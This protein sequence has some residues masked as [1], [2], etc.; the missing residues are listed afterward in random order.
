MLVV[1]TVCLPEE[2]EQIHRLN[3]QN[4]KQNLSPEEKEKEG[5]VTWLYPLP[6]LQQLHGLLPSVIAKNG[7]NVVGYALSTPKE[8]AAF[9]PELKAM[10]QNL[11]ALFFHQKRV[12]DMSYYIMG[13]ICI[14][15]AYRGQGILSLLYGHHKQVYSQL[16]Q[17]LVTEISTS[18]PR[19]QK[20]HEKVGFTTI[21]T[22]RDALDE[23]NVVVWDWN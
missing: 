23:W 2:L 5:F 18:N 6:L 12:A 1:T 14:A 9:H 15:K 17:L 19:S 16:Y 13:Q 22:Y 11:E 10:V 4:L 21:H 20:A 8:A 7:P 3:K